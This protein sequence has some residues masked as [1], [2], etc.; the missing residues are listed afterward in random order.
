MDENNKNNKNAYPSKQ[1]W[2]KEK[3]IKMQKTKLLSSLAAILNKCF[4]AVD[5][6]ITFWVY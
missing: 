3:K 5:V 4:A 2:K 6:V 1:E